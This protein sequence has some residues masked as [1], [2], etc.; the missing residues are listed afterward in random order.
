MPGALI[1]AVMMLVAGRLA[2]KVDRRWI[3]W[4]GLSMFALGSY[5]FSFLTLE[6]PMRWIIWMIAWRYAAIPFIFTP[7]NTASL[8]LLPP[9]KVRMGSGLVNLLQQG[10]G[11][12]LGLALMT[13]LLQQRTAVHTT[14]L[15]Q[16]QTLSS[17]PWGDVLGG[18]QNVVSQAG[19]VGAMVDVK[20][21]ALV[22]QH[23]LQQATVAAYQDCF[24]LL[25]AMA[26]MIMPLVFFLR[27]R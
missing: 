5:W 8:L 7:M 27:R 17:L 4:G 16:H 24:V 6:R 14:L 20:A 12:T 15:D 23:L 21:W 22:Y 1:L 3:V 11:G 13:T 18:V 10:V 25:A 2:D 19:D 26:V 9:D